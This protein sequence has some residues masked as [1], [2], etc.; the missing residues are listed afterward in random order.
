MARSSSLTLGYIW[1]IAAIWAVIAYWMQPAI[2]RLRTSEAAVEL[3]K[4]REGLRLEAYTDAGGR[5]TI[6]YGHTKNVTPDMTISLR[7]A[8][9]LFRQ[10][11]RGFELDIKHRL[12]VPVNK[13]Q[14]SAMVVL[15][16]NI[17]TSAF[18]NS[19]VLRELNAGDHAE[20]AE[21]FLLWDKIRLD[22]QPVSS[23]YLKMHRYKERTMFLE[24]V[25]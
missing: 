22:G 10:D 24:P 11:V 5:L 16:Y 6:G 7:E 3:I 18:G 12:Q 15:V 8:E 23:A 2:A 9:K 21:A 4:E 14:F 19:T 25:R 17:G 1:L 20:A 13:N